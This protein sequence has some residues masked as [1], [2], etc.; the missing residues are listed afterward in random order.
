MEKV[1]M[2]AAGFNRLQEELKHLKITERPAV[3]KAIAEAREHGDLSE[4]AEYHAARERQSFIE[5]RVLE[6]EDK[7]SRAEVID[8]AKLTGNTVKFGATV[9]LADQDTDEETTYQIVGQD[10]SDIKNRLLS[11]QAPLA[12]ALINKSVGDSVEVS[13]PG[14]SKLYEIVSVEFR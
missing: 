11:I 2:T 12:R 4:N 9:T 7:I 13:T 6:L 14:G 8:P 3:I 5:G 1:P 10:E